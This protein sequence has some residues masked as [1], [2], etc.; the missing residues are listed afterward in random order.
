[1]EKLIKSFTGKALQKPHNGIDAY[2]PDSTLIQAINLS[3][4]LQRP[5]LI[6]GDPG[7]GKTRLAE[8]VAYEWY[9][10]D[11]MKYYFRW[12]IKSTS[13]AKEGLYSFDHLKKLYDI[14][15][16]TIKGIKT[17]TSNGVEDNRSYRTFGKLGLAFINSTPE[18]PCVLLID[19][20]DKAPLDF[21]NDLLLELDEKKFIIPETAETI[22][23][24]NP[25]LI[26]ITSNSEK[27]LPAAFL[28]R[29]IYH[30]IEFPNENLLRNILSA[31]LK[32]DDILIEKGLK[33]FIEIRHRQESQNIAGEKLVSTSEMID[34]FKFLSHIIKH[35]GTS[36]MVLNDLENN[37]IPYFQA[38]FK[39]REDYSIFNENIVKLDINEH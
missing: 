14:Q 37:R 9:K 31:N 1:M 25:L 7:C 36:K 21:P 35:Q 39:Q 34:W 12:D 38:L 2:V 19:E 11:F 24:D 6:T 16:L 30:H 15:S 26:I 29:C 4:F 18:K 5:L 10:K 33:L 23:S 8:A 32:I 17:E 22:V 28:R 27:E 13:K 20:I 3:F